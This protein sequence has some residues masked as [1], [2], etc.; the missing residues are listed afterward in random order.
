MIEYAN[1]ISHPFSNALGQQ[2]ELVATGARRTWK[3]QL[4]K[5]ADAL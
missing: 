4:G 3:S 2:P 5:S 1:R